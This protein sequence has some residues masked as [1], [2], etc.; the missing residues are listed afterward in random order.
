[1]IDNCIFC[2]IV[3]REAPA[4]LVYEDERVIAFLSNRP[5]NLGHTLVVCKKHYEN[6]FDISEDELAYLY[7]IVKKVAC[8]VREGKDA[9]G[10]KII[11]NNGE[12]AD[13][14]IFH[15]HVHI[16]PM[17]EPHSFLSER[18]IATSESLENEAEK[19]RNFL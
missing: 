16:I 11:Q 5:I 12:V 19:I 4:S 8:A 10:I 14:V 1:M 6:I 13:Q 9:K 3:N 2:Q 18:R 7:R 15:I 17:S